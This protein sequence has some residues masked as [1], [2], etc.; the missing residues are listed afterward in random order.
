ML[1]L[2]YVLFYHFSSIGDTDSSSKAIQQIQLISEPSR[3]NKSVEALA[4]VK[5]AKL[6]KADPYDNKTPAAELYQ[7]AFSSKFQSYQT[8]FNY[9]TLFYR[10]EVPIYSTVI[11]H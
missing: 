5:Q 11:A 1:E 10:K 2:S 3:E 8:R 4:Y 7:S 9:H 6:A